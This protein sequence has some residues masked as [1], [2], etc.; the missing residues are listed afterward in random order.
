M[1]LK[2]N[3]K[4]LNNESKLIDIP[5]IKHFVTI[6]QTKSTLDLIPEVISTIDPN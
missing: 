4:V 3:D 5:G 2:L 6:F 1:S